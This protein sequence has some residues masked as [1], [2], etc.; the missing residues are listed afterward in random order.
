MKI[1]VPDVLL[2]PLQRKF[3]AQTVLFGVS[4]DQIAYRRKLYAN[5]VV[6]VKG[7]LV[8]SAPSRLGARDNLGKCGLVPSFVSSSV[9]RTH[10]STLPVLL[11]T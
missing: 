3:P 6:V 9:G 7:H 11:G 2:K 4:V 10:R 5:R 1:L 8:I